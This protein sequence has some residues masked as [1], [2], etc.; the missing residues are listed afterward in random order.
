MIR[1]PEHIRSSRLLS[2]RIGAAP[3]RT[4]LPT[5]T[6]LTIG[7][8]WSRACERKFRALDTA[9]AQARF[10][11]TPDTAGTVGLMKMSVLNGKLPSADVTFFQRR[12]LSPRRLSPASPPHREGGYGGGFFAGGRAQQNEVHKLTRQGQ[13]FNTPAQGGRL[14]RV[15]ATKATR[16]TGLQAS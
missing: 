14:H 8:S 1:R 7:F 12:L 3:F 11:S 9:R 2:Q 10:P 13:F 15:V 5:R 6:A 4:L 16:T